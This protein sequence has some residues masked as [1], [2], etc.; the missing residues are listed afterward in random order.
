M[1][2]FGKV[3]VKSLRNKTR[4]RQ[5]TH[6]RTGTR[7]RPAHRPALRPAL[8]CA[9]RRSTRPVL[10]DTGPSFR[11]LCALFNKHVK[12]VV[13]Y[14]KKRNPAWNEGRFK[15]LRPPWENDRKCM[16]DLERIYGDEST[17]AQELDA[18]A[19]AAL[20]QSSPAKT[21]S[22]TPAATPAPRTSNTPPVSP[23]TPS[24]SPKPAQP[25]PSVPPA[26]PSNEPVR[27]DVIQVPLVRLPCGLLGLDYKSAKS[28]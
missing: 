11:S 23:P 1:A 26:A 4:R 20:Q 14:E 2:K 13:A 3:L 10:P 6:N 12:V 25:S 8:R 19:V 24:V 15:M 9:V 17:T 7:F 21:G 28:C 22:V 27:R 16:E 18:Q 5:V